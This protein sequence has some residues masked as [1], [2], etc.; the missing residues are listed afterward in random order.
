MHV[1]LRIRDLRDPSVQ[2]PGTN[3]TVEGRL[4]SIMTKIAEDIK[5][6]GSAIDHYVKKGFLGA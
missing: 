2:F 1:P 5:E 4:G 6:T 3:E